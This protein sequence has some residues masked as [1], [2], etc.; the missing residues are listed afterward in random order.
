MAH[1]RIQPSPRLS[2]FGARRAVPPGSGVTSHRA[3]R[4]LLE[5]GRDVLR[6]TT[7]ISVWRLH[8]HISTLPS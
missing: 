6:F 1:E 7:N 4:E 5:S 3:G 2:R 8:A